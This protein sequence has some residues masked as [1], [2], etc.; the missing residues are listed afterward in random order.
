MP[1]V[2]QTFKGLVESMCGLVKIKRDLF[3]SRRLVI[4]LWL[5]DA[6]YQI[7]ASIFL[8]DILLV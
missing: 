6:I 1:I 7:L 5:N 2:K 3:N 8:Y 4:T